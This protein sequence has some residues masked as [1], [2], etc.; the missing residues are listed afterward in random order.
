MRQDLFDV[1]PDT[2]SRRFRLLLPAFE[3][4]L[5]RQVD[6]HRARTGL[7]RLGRAVHP[8]NH[9]VV[10]TGSPRRVRD[11]LLERRSLLGKCFTLP[12]D[13]IAFSILPVHRLLNLRHSRRR[14]AR[15]R[16]VLVT[17]LID[18]SDADRIIV[19]RRGVRRSSVSACL[20]RGARP[21]VVASRRPVQLGRQLVVA[22]GQCIRT[23][24]GERPVVHAVPTPGSAQERVHVVRPTASPLA[25]TLSPVPSPFLLRAESAACQTSHRQQDV[26]VGIL[27]ILIVISDVGHHPARGELLSHVPA[28]QPSTLLEAELTR[29]R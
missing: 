17:G 11:P 7:L 9:F 20:D 25:D 24:C 21:T 12:P 3:G 26:N 13:R 18:F 8:V 22:R 10:E 14:H 1:D 19:R 5:R 28:H 6:G 29:Q 16:N 2:A 15:L 23:L 4:R 27:S